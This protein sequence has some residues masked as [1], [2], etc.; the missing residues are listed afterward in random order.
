MNQD[1]ILEMS[2]RLDREGYSQHADI[3]FQH[4][5]KSAALK[6][7]GIRLAGKDGIDKEIISA[8]HMKDG[9]DSCVLKYEVALT[10]KPTFAHIHI[11]R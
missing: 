3:F 11:Y 7:T 4:A 10:N 2:A 8:K 9:E 5:I 6:Q 1:L